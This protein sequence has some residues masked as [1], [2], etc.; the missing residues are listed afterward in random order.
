VLVGIVVAVAIALRWGFAATAQVQ[1]PLR[2]DAG[3]YASYARNLVEHGVYSL[4]TGS[5]PAPDSF[6]SPGYPWFL[7]CCRLVGGEHWLAWAFALQVACGG[8]TV[9]CAYRLARTLLGFWPSL[10]A[11]ALCALSPHL[12]VTS[13]YALTECLTTFLLSAGLCLAGAV[14][15]RGAAAAG[16]AGAVLGLGALANEVFVFVPIAVACALW[17]SL[18]AARAGAVLACGLLPWCGWALRNA[19]TDLARTGGQRVVASVSH[20]SYPG[21]V[22]RDPRW[23]GYPYRE[24]P[25]QPAFGSSWTDLGRVLGARAAASPW[26]YASWYLLEKPLWLWRF[27][28]VQGRGVLV[29]EA[30]NDPYERQAV[31]AAT[32]ALMRWLHLPVMLGAA[33]AALLCAFGC[34]RAPGLAGALGLTVVG[35]TL[36]YLPVIPDPRYL[37]PVRPFLFVLAAAAG[38]VAVRAAQRL[39]WR[40]RSASSAAENGG[41]SVRSPEPEAA[42]QAP[43][44]A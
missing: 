4:G 23:T 3:E 21:M 13:G 16:G 6:R 33:A 32:G 19:T 11:A 22:H 40:S 39:C 30:G 8:L 15:H 10:A 24:D 29:Y 1:N 34:R 43:P 44:S 25:E 42:E 5:P 26:R 27:D 38:T 41:P 14:R 9:L 17:R 20:G 36:A 31:V 18:G 12:V 37:T 2:A 28:Y 7:A 35:G